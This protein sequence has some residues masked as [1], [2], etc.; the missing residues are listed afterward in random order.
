MRA[1]QTAHAAPPIDTLTSARAHGGSGRGASRHAVG[2]GRIDG[3]AVVRVL[4]IQAVC[5][6]PARRA[7]TPRPYSSSTGDAEVHIA[8][9]SRAGVEVLTGA[10]GSTLQLCDC[11]C[12]PLKGWLC[13]DQH[14]IL[15][16]HSLFHSMHSTCTDAVLYAV[17]ARR[18]RPAAPLGGSAPARPCAP[19]PPAARP[20]P[21]APAAA[22][23][24]SR[25]GRVQ[26]LGA[27]TLLDRALVENLLRL[28]APC[29][30]AS[31]Q[32]YHL[33]RDGLLFRTWTAGAVDAAGSWVAAH[34]GLPIPV[35]CPSTWPCVMYK[36][37]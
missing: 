33:Q 22:R 30:G 13:S 2:A 27:G 18:C 25:A 26:A 8:A 10:H 24:A 16:H 19:C 9:W 23:A 6:A 31:K 5:L 7:L 32:L 28:Q 37:T 21:A 35:T 34:S 14:A 4:T 3:R 12:N 1:L 17:R 36:P 29:E 15:H 11:L 20:H